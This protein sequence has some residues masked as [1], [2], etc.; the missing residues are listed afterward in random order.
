MENDLFPRQCDPT[1]TKQ[2]LAFDSRAASITN[3]ARYPSSKVAAPSTLVRPSRKASMIFE[4]KIVK[5]CDQLDSR[6]PEASWPWSTSTRRQEPA[7]A[8]ECQ[9]S[10]VSSTISAPLLP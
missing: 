5:P 2:P 8:G 4:E 1:L 10:P 6:M 9:S 3:C 7:P